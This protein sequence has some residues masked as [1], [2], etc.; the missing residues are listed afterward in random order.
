MKLVV[1]H[2]GA[3]RGYAVPSILETAGM[4]ECFY[5]DICADVGLGR[6][7]TLVLEL[8]LRTRRLRRLA[9]RRLPTN[10]VDKTTTFAMPNVKYYFSYR[11]S[12]AG[13]EAFLANLRWQRELGDRMAR[14]GFGEATWLHSFLDE[15]PTLIVAA[16]QQGLKVISEIYIL[17]SSGRLLRDERRQF[18]GWEQDVPDF[19]KIGREAFGTRV[20]FTH[21]D[22]ILC[23]SESVR[24]DAIDNFGF[25]RQ[26][27][28]VVP[29]GVGDAW[30]RVRNSPVR[31]RVLF[32]GTA[33]L[34]KGIHYLGMAAEHF[35]R[36][37]SQYDFRV[38][39][40]VQK[41]VASQSVCRRLKFLGSVP[42]DE[43]AHEFT[44]ADV[45]VL[46]SL[47]EGSAGVTYEAL[48]AGVPVITTNAAG[49]V[50]RDGIEGRIVP[51]RDPGALAHAI[52]EV[53][54]DREKRDRM[55]HAARERAK[56]FTW[57]RY[58]E[59][60]VTALK[61]FSMVKSESASA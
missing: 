28:L 60:L 33:E 54:E 18:P 57:E 19:E 12:G 55:A 17:L 48:A 47:A 37:R 38:A 41:T 7:L 56:E 35:A 21:S 22:F 10:I 53:T 51:E 9:S 4:L 24:N 29:Y 16:K 50:V 13:A 44:Q 5:T 20:L 46:P 31:R 23:P 49:S 2:T 15:F 34:R 11:R 40:E 59:R 25:H 43:I 3:R 14:S 1:A 58:G 61:R 32:A 39:G 8:G 30:F 27:S 26:R 52:A 45:F 6:A 42:R 36:S